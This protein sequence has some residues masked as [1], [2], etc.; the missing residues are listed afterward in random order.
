[1]L[2][3]FRHAATIPTGRRYIGRTEVPLSE[4]GREQAES[5][6]ELLGDLPLAA[7]YA[8]PQKRALDTAHLLAQ[9][10]GLPVLELEQLRE[11]HLGAWEGLS[12][13]EVARSRPEEYKARGNDFAGFRPPGGESFADVSKRAQAALEIMVRGPRPGIAFTH[14]GV[15]RVLACLALNVPLNRLFDFRPAHAA[16]WAFELDAPKQK[17]SP[18]P[19]PEKALP[20]CS[21]FLRHSLPF[22]P[23]LHLI[24]TNLSPLQARHLLLPSGSKHS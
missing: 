12:M 24:G 10:T 20:P 18:F 21:P 22:R 17:T 15:L 9:K 3:F 16:C 5:L 8:S 6:A 13:A 4:H 1:V 14:A 11:I 19:S 23:N 2:L 7:L